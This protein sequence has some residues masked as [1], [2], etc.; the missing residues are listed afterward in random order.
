MSGV[1]VGNSTSN[2]LQSTP[3]GATSCSGTPVYSTAFDYFGYLTYAQYTA[4]NGLPTFTPTQSPTTAPTV[5]HTV[6][7]IA[8]PTTG[9]P[10]VP[11]T[12]APSSLP[13]F[14]PTVAPIVA[15]LVYLSTMY[16]AD[17]GCTR[18]AGQETFAMNACLPAGTTRHL[19]N[20]YTTT[21]SSFNI[22]TQYYSDSACTTAVGT[23]DAYAATSACGL[24]HGNAYGYATIFNAPPTTFDAKGTLLT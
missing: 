24:N 15:P 12:L 19:F 8:V 10:S 14:S 13:T 20:S 4:V 2:C 7:P 16:F 21:P 11:P 22:V 3:S 23:P 9:A 17:A 1:Y 18:F 6:A 5:A